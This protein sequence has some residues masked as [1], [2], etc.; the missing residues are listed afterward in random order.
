MHNGHAPN[1]QAA[2][3]SAAL[4]RLLVGLDPVQ[5][6]QRLGEL[7]DECK[8]R[9]SVQKPLNGLKPSPS[10]T[11][12]NGAAETN[13]HDKKTGRF[14]PGNQCGRGNPHARRQAALRAVLF[15]A[16][17]EDRLRGIA[18]RLATLAENGDM[19]ACK[20][21]FAYL[22]GKPGAA[23]DPDR[24]DLEE[25]KLADAQPTVHE[26][27]RALVDN[28]DA[29]GACDHLRRR[30]PQDAQQLSER[31]VADA[32][33]SELLAARDKRSRRKRKASSAI[34]G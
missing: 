22:L 13:G 4:E 8:L 17:G 34:P 26:L 29:R 15:D 33:P 30:Q 32:N 3:T 11:V 2:G 19:E 1:G 10:A 16:V 31:I 20:L 9:D 5:R 12:S 14:A 27:A 25:W 7:L 28:V 23:P 18:T 6:V 21:L 24:L